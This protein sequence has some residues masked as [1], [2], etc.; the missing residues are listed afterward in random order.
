MIVVSLVM[1]ARPVIIGIIL[2]ESGTDSND[3]SKTLPMIEA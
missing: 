2:S 3:P 1:K